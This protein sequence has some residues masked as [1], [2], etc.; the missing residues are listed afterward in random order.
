[1]HSC[2]VQILN[3]E[4]MHSEYQ[5]ILWAT[6]EHKENSNNASCIYDWQSHQS[7]F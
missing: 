4:E 2:I 5:N 3:K 1:M 6:A 7:M